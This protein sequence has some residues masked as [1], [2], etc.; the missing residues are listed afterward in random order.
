MQKLRL[1]KDTSIR[2]YACRIQDDNVGFIKYM[3]SIGY[4]L[5]ANYY[6]KLIFEKVRKHKP[7]HPSSKEQD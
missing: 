5:I 4:K 2:E 3:E 1:I 6:T 7:P